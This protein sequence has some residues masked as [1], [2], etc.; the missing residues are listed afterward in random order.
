MSPVYAHSMSGHCATQRE[1]VGQ[2]C[3]AEARPA[4]RDMSNMYI[5]GLPSYSPAPQMLP[6][7]RKYYLVRCGCGVTMSTDLSVG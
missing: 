1:G 3:S 7:L 2:P 4:H 5:S 6:A